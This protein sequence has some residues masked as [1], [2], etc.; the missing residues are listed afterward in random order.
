MSRKNS[1]RFKDIEVIISSAV[2][3]LRAI[4]YSIEALLL[5]IRSMPKRKKVHY[6]I[7]NSGSE[8]HKQFYVVIN[9]QA[10]QSIE[11][12]NIESVNH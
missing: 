3:S 9:P 1:V 2:V 4:R 8:V 11:N 6:Y 12:W 7:N 10:Q 5:A